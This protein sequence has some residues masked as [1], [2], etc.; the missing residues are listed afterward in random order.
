MYESH[1]QA[2]F[3]SV[4]AGLGLL[5]LGIGSLVSRRWPVWLQVL[6]MGAA[7]LPSVALLAV[8]DRWYCLPAVAGILAAGC[9]IHVLLGSRFW[10]RGL[11]LA[12]ETLR[13]PVVRSG[14]LFATGPC[15]AMG[16]IVHFEQ[17]D[18]RITDEVINEMM[19]IHGVAGNVQ[20]RNA[21]ALTDRGRRIPLGEPIEIRTP[22]WIQR[23]ERRY[24]ETTQ[25]LGQVI[26]REFGDDRSN[27]HGWVFTGGRY[28]ISGQ[29]VLKILEDN[30][31]HEVAEPQPND[32]AIYYN[33]E[34]L[35]AHTAVVRYV[36]PGQPVLV[37]GK[38]GNLGVFLHPAADCPY[39]PIIKYYRTH[40]EQ[41]QLQIV[42]SDAVPAS[43]EKVSPEQ[44][45]TDTA[46]SE[47]ASME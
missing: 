14:I 19:L 28:L 41:H 10:S 39:G 34:Y 20:V 31:Y 33:H 47:S 2:L 24:L 1:F 15:L 12:F 23:S 45:R 9:S 35:V 4:A 16:G 13:R 44:R 32:L 37:E 25:R 22:E 26:L 29:D 7:C 36:A 38:W 3:V 18:E 40:R 11:A 8:L 46:E 27:C 42:A 21:V 17:V 6:A 43:E 30:G 5:L